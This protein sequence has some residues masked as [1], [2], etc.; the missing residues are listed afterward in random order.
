MRR[1]PQITKVAPAGKY[2]LRLTFDDG[3]EGEIDVSKLIKFRGV[4]APLRDLR[5]FERV[6]VVTNGGTIAWPNGADLDPIVL[7]A[8]VTKQSVESLLA[9]L[10]VR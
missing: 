10:A 3:A 4:F 5:E 7:Y 6:F 8:A 2:C 1:I 9:S